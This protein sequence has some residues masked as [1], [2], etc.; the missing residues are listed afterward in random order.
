VGNTN[1]P[2]NPFDA[3]DE[4]LAKLRP[5]K[6]KK[7][8]TKIQDGQAPIP[9]TNNQVSNPVNQRDFEARMKNSIKNQADLAPMS[10]GL[11]SKAYRSTVAL[12]AQQ[13]A[14]LEARKHAHRAGEM[15]E[16]TTIDMFNVINELRAKIDLS[17]VGELKTLVDTYRAAGT[18]LRRAMG[19][20]EPGG[21]GNQQSGALVQVQCLGNVVLNQSDLGDDY[22]VV[23]APGNSLGLPDLDDVFP[24]EK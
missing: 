19:I 5:K 3:L 6:S 21:A 23:Q 1:T 10:Q 12:T 7:A 22:D 8:N 24:S 4:R 15:I 13:Y 17:E 18:E 2:Q 14:D 9:D 20:C 16:K 11:T